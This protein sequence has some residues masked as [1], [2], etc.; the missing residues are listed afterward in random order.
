MHIVDGIL[1]AP[2]LIGSGI[3][4][5]A[6]VWRGLRDIDA[7]TMPFVAVMTAGF[8]L[9]S[10]VHVP[11]GP[12]N[13]HLALTGLMGL[14]LGWA[15][16]PA[17]LVGLVLQ[18]LFFGFGG[19]TVLGT[20][21]LA[22]A[23]PAVLVGLTLGLGLSSSPRWS[24]ALRGFVAGGLG[25]MLGALAIAA[26]LALSGREFWLAAQLVVIGQV[27]VMFVDGLVTSAALVLLL[28]VRPDLILRQRRALAPQQV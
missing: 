5:A 7:D 18:A 17:V 27:P 26:V 8:F 3:L 20:N 9:A 6:G 13:A 23:M 16:F 25:V 24:I 11:I 15:A 28:Q 21:T 12:V 22:M 2:V 10:L 1:S 14:V 19:L 4:A